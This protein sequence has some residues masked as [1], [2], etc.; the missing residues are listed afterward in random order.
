MRA[1]RVGALLG[2]LGWLTACSGE[3]FATDGTGGAAS[4]GAAGAGGGVG[5][6]SGGGGVGAVGGA[7][8]GGAGG[9]SGSGG[10][11]AVGGTTTGGTGG[12]SGGS[13]G[14]SG[15]S[16]G[17][18]ATCG[19]ILMSAVLLYTTLNDKESIEQPAIIAGNGSGY[20]GPGNT[21]VDGQCGSALRVDEKTDCAKFPAPGNI[22]FNLGTIDFYFRP[23][24]Q[25]ADNQVHYLF[26]LSDMFMELKKSGAPENALVLG[27]K[28]T[29]LAS[30]PTAKLTFVQGQWTR[31]T[32]TWSNFAGNFTTKIY[33]DG[34]ELGMTTQAYPTG[35]AGLPQYMYIG[36]YQCNHASHG[37]G[38]FD[39]FK[40][41]DKVVLPN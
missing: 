3:E 29:P 39:D 18:V 14:A 7:T 10:V 38:D 27:M 34:A 41:Y 1:R 17:S 4:G 24:F 37:M 35:D 32:V 30:I 15:G 20:P 40:I 2:V 9:A 6:S 31:V 16:G 33:L 26:T 11:G 19:D 22:G 23:N 12:A 36:N 21:H 25:K 5:G 8:T 13:G 28:G